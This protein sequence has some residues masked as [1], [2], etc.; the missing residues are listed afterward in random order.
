MPSEKSIKIVLQWLTS[1][2]SP[3][4]KISEISAGGAAEMTV[5]IQRGSMAILQPPRSRFMINDIL[6]GAAPQ[7]GNGHLHHQLGLTGHHHHH[8]QLAALHHH[9]TD[10][11]SSNG[12]DG[13]DDNRS[14]SPGPRDLTLSANGTR[15]GQHHLP[16][17]SH[18]H[19]LAALNAHHRLNGSDPAGEDSD[20]DSSGNDNHSVS[21]NGELRRRIV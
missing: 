21:S 20:S 15:P 3:F 18:H 12:R 13:S 4:S 2:G 7:N 9:L 17:L 1:G 5:P 10:T 14:P 6:G 19:H 11:S 8:H 16:M